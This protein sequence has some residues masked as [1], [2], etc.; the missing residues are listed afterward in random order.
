M[1]IIKCESDKYNIKK[2]QVIG[3]IKL[4]NSIIEFT[5][6]NNILYCNGN[7]NLEN[8][9]LRFTG[10]NSIIYF[11]KNRFSFSIDIRVG[12]DSLF[13]LGK[14]CYLN[15]KSH[16]YATERKNIIIGNDCL[17]SFDNYLRTADPHLIY[18]INTRK[19]INFS[20][21]ILIGD[22]VWIGQE[23]LILKGTKIGSGAIIGGHAT[24]NKRVESNTVYAGNPA[25]K[26]RE[27]VYFKDGYSSNNYKL[28]DEIN[29]EYC[30]NNKGI[31]KKDKNTISLE[32][33]DN[34]IRKIDNVY[35]KLVFV[36]ENLTN[37]TH[38]NRFFI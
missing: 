8:S 34:A 37:N 28:E 16:M 1:E 7:I 11:D 5:G 30:N 38:K 35:D 15:R 10:S 9:T 27:N 4:K 22:H 24:L 12:F 26:I 25:R 33:L 14:N 13:Y 23:C 29:S 3:N 2:N 18:D 19:R 32:Q 6:D 21:S 20:K 17:I 36:Q 31:F